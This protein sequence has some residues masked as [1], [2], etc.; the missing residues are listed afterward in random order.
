MIYDVA[1]MERWKQKV[2]VDA[3]FGFRVSLFSPTSGFR[4][5]GR[6]NGGNMKGKGDECPLKATAGFDA[7]ENLPPTGLIVSTGTGI[8]N[9]H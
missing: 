3:G 9:R 5:P 6:S 7:P 8:V 4:F 2:Q 1:N